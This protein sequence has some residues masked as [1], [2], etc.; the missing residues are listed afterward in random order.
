MIKFRFLTYTNFGLFEKWYEDLAREG[1]QI[2]SLPLPFVHK[3]K[4]APAAEMKYRVIMAPNEG[5]Y[6]AF[7]KDELDDY[8]NM[9]E[10]FGWKLVDRSFNNNVYKL[11]KGAADSL[12][13]DA[14]EEKEILTKGIKGEIIAMV[15]SLFIFLGLFFL[16]SGSFH[17][18]SIFY[19]NSTLFNYPASIL[20][21]VFIFLSIGD[22]IVFK[23]RNKDVAAVRDMKFS[24]LS[25]SKTYTFLICVS[26]ILIILGLIAQILSFGGNVEKIWILLLPLVVFF[27]TFFSIKKVKRLNKKTRTKKVLMVVIPILIIILVSIAGSILMGQWT[28]NN[29]V[30]EDAGDFK[31]LPMEKSVLT[32]SH[33]LYESKDMDLRIEKTKVKNEKLARVLSERIIKNASNHPYE[34]VLVKDLTGDFPYEKTYRLAGEKSF[35]VL[36]GPTVLEV[37]GDIYDSEVQEQVEKILEV[38]RWLGIN[39]KH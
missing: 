3:F 33:D 22:Y 21:L 17:S 30:F 38:E 6:S 13:N 37:S 25:F 7:S 4:K 23:K 34:S 35:L 31:K 1:W 28:N 29:F 36:Y 8:K 24:K 5:Y 26:L 15:L 2:E 27:V 39:S 12:Y 18:S 16:I 11:E 19:S 10:D 9:A 14:K 32:S 20:L